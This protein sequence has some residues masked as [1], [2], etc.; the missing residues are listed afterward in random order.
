MHRRALVLALLCGMAA[1]CTQPQS[2]RSTSWFERLRAAD[3]GKDVI[4]LDVALLER[5]IGDAF[6][7]RELWKYTDEQTVAL[8]RKAVLDDNGFRVGQIVGMPPG[9][10][11]ALLSSERSCINPRRQMLPPG[12]ATV[13][14]LG[15]TLPHAE[16]QVSE[17]G[18]TVEI[19]L[20]QAQ[21]V[22]EV[23]PTLAGDGKTRLRFAPKVQYGEKVPELHPAADGS[24]WAF[25]ISRPCRQ[26]PAVTWEVCIAPN[27]FLVVGAG[28]D[29]PDSFGYHAFIQHDATAQVQRLLVIRTNRS[30][31]TQTATLED[32]A[33][34]SPP[35]AVQATMSAA[36][37]H[38][39]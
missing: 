28:S 7:D 5:P 38:G 31:D 4:Q 6:L 21:F 3:F 11:Q 32:L 20:E 23:T 16:F 39:Q 25:E 14:V 30:A 36:R 35:L 2:A 27:E 29:Q 33:R 24:D 37:A 10:L 26:F 1:G 15:P 19:A 34:H 17:N 12:R 18:Q 13:Q 8:D 9:K 22:L